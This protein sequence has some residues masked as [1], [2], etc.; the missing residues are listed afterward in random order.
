[1]KSQVPVTETKLWISG[2]WQPA[3]DGKTFETLNPAT[4][5][6]IA[7][8]SRASASDVD[9]AVMAA[10]KAFASGPWPRMKSHERAGVLF[11]IASLFEER[12]EQTACLETLDCG[13]PIRD[14]RSVDLPAVIQ[15]LRYY[16]G[17]TDKFSGETL[18]P[19]PDYFSYTLR[20][21][22]GVVGIITPWNFPLLM[23]VQKTAA[24]LA[25]GNTVILKPAEQ[26]P[27]TALVFA[28]LAARAGLPEG[29]LN[30][31]PG[32]GEDAGAALVGHPGV[33]AIAFT[34]EYRTGQE[35]MKNAAATLKKL[36]FELGGKS[37]SIIFADAD[38]EKAAEFACEGIFFNQGEVCCAG[39]R[40]FVEESVRE[41][42]LKLLLEK[43]RAWKPGDPM[44]PQTTL[45]PLV[46]REQYDKV[47][48]CI[49]QG[50]AEGAVLAL[51]GRREG[52]KGL[53]M[54]PTVFTGAHPS[55][56]IARREIF[57]PVLTEMP[58]RDFD[59]VLEQANGTFYGLAASVWTRDLAKAHRAVRALQAG[60][61]WVNCY[62]MVDHALPFGG[63]KMSG[64]GREGGVHTFDFF[65]QLKTVWIR[66]E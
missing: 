57:G 1:M 24:A 12:L 18:S 19:D 15:A 46:S 60:T 25:A 20:E 29:V 36:S 58:F 14:S 4:G 6:V 17:W 34:G 13:K 62:G 43:S 21:P 11:R 61:V 30:V 41:R 65:T 51:D 32:F 37:P 47:Q 39:S 44:D 35:I 2:R 3:A 59:Q 54:G 8:V 16:A 10:R 22:L 52:E 48:G 55:M 7:L 5:E 53:F 38:L 56:E 42:F 28:E 63:Y 9:A 26:T 66:L 31:L 50:V 40:I 49:R 45:G 23:A 64:S 27:L 33:D